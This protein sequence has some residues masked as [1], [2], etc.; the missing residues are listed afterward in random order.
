MKCCECGKEL[1]LKIEVKYPVQ[2]EECAK[3]PLIYPDDWN[4]EIDAGNREAD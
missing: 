1:D 3:K 4:E 2:C